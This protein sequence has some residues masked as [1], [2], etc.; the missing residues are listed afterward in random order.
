MLLHDQIRRIHFELSSL[1]NAACPNCPRNVHGGETIH[2]LLETAI[3]IEQFKQILDVDTLKQLEEIRFCGNYGDPVTAKDLPDIVEWIY[4][5]NSTVKI[6]INTNGGLRG[7]RWWTRLGKLMA[8]R[9]DSAVIFSI[10]GLSDTNDIY[11]RNVQWRKL[12]EHFKAFIAAGG[13]A[14]WEMLVFQHNEH[15][16]REARLLAKELGFVNFRTKIPFG[17][18]DTFNSTNYML[19]LDRAGEFES[20]LWPAG[21]TPQEVPEQSMTP[22][23]YN[24]ELTRAHKAA[25][26][27]RIEKQNYY[28]YMDNNYPPG[29]DCMSIRDREIYI[30]SQ[31]YLYPCCFL[32]HSGQVQRG[33]ESVLFRRWISENVG[34]DSLDLYKHS[35]RD[36]VNSDY[37][38][39]IEDTWN[40][41]HREGR[42]AMCSLMCSSDCA[43]NRMKNLY[44]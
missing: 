11:R 15:Q 5:H 44:D 34:W 14:I 41:D 1:C 21:A 7:A 31:G 17:F 25:F 19:V 37:F 2:N 43:K 23:E 10:D 24:L 16:L 8:G 30:D 29:I 42:I 26:D 18:N 28:D 33:R 39:L 20:A 6:E 38:K 40:K 3:R 32:G 9:G 36:I 12:E 4:S 27:D 22:P 35:I 13:A